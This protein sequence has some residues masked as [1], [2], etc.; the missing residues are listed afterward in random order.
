MPPSHELS[1]LEGLSK[2]CWLSKQ[3]QTRFRSIVLKWKQET[4]KATIVQQMLF[5]SLCR[6]HLLEQRLIDKRLFWD[7]SETDY[8]VIDPQRKMT[9]VG[10]EDRNRK[11]REFEKWYPQVM[12]WKSDLLKLALAEKIEL[13]GEVFDIASLVTAYQKGRNGERENSNGQCGGCRVS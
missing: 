2:Q 8:R 10:D 9:D 13:T 11:A 6:V 4:P 12:R 3:E 7:G 1:T 5:E